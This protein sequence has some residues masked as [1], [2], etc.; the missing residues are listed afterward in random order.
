MYVEYIPKI[1]VRSYGTVHVDL[2]CLQVDLILHVSEPNR[3]GTIAIA[4][5]TTAE[6][7]AAEDRVE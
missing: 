5:A 7:S 4:I 6:K 3:S 1:Y 2:V